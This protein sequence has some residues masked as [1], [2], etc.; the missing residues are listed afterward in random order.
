MHDTHEIWLEAPMGA[1]QFDA[2]MG[3]APANA[4]IHL[5]VGEFET[6][7]FMHSIGGWHPKTGQRISGAGMGLTTIKLVGAT[8]PYTGD[9]YHCIKFPFDPALSPDCFEVSDLTIDCNSDGQL[10]PQ[11]SCGAIAVPA[12]GRHVRLRR[13][14]VI[15]FGSHGPSW[16]YR[17][18]FVLYI[19]G[20]NTV[21][22]VIEDC[23]AEQPSPKVAYN[24][25]VL[26]VGGSFDDKRTYYARGCAIRHN[27]VSCQVDG[28]TLPHAMMAADN[29]TAAVVEGNR[30]LHGSTGGPWHDTASTLDL[31]V[32]NNYY[33]DVWSGPHQNMG[34]QY[35][36]GTP[37]TVGIWS[38][39]NNVIV[40]SANVP[41]ATGVMAGIA[42][43]DRFESI[44]AA[45]KQ[46]LVKGNIIRQID[47]GVDCAGITIRSTGTLRVEENI[48]N[49]GSPIRF[50]KS[51][52]PSFFNNLNSSGQLHYVQTEL[53]TD[54]EDAILLSV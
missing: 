24:S 14:R 1:E 40:L 4:V 38:I 34:Y 39:E 45:F 18:N 3:S 47:D 33:Y 6:K 30:L 53:T 27:Y 2:I 26:L 46:V 22:C 13:V 28:N 15:D 25:I 5:G 12:G 41:S 37:A 31:E 43:P 32:R 8:K 54:I 20:P 50:S 52:A 36:D 42:D 48:I 49:A 7:G 11:V 17:E 29:G 9:E 35:A 51:A 44:P 21:D 10:D 16:G 19:A 23:V